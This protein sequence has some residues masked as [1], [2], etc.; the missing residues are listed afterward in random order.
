MKL[1]KVRHA[2]KKY[3]QLSRQ[4]FKGKNQ[5]QHFRI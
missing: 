2:L 5:A 3:K 4:N 1:A